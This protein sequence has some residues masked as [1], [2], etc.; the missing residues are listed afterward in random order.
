L[1]RYT[2]DSAPPL[3]ARYVEHDTHAMFTALMGPTAAA[4]PVAAAAERAA[5]AGADTRPL[6]SST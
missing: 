3:D 2:V 6:L 1:R 4:A 5:A